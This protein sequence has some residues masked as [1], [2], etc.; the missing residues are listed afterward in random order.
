M[1][2]LLWQRS[3]ILSPTF[4]AFF[5]QNSTCHGFVDPHTAQKWPCGPPYPPEMA[6]CDI[7]PF[8]QIKNSFSKGKQSEDVQTIKFTTTQQLLEIPTVY[9]EGCVR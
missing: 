9:C 7:L 3:G 4:A 8:L 1:E 6:P 5:N 2:N